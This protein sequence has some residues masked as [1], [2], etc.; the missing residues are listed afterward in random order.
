MVGDENQRG[1][2]VVNDGGGF[3]L[4]K[5]GE[6]AFKINSAVAAVS[7]RQIE[8]YSIIGRSDIAEHFARALGKRRAA[9]ICVNDNAGAIDHRLN[10][11]G[12]QLFNRRSDKI[13]NR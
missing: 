9:K 4:A 3:G 6:R 10:A 13:D 7:G 12:A 2:A 1:G 8:L 5:N 11:T